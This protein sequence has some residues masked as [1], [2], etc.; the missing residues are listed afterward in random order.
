MQEFGRVF[1]R[2]DKEVL[3]PGKSKIVMGTKAATLLEPD[4]GTGAR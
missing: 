2:V 4:R 1:S 3:P